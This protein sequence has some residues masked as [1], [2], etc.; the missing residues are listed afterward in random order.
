[1]T[2]FKFKFLCL[3]NQFYSKKDELMCTKKLGRERG[4]E[5]NERIKW[6]GGGGCILNILNRGGDYWSEV[7]NYGFGGD[8][9]GIE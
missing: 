8:E 3:N 2:K 7:L 1:M 9:E 5:M 4:G 6:M